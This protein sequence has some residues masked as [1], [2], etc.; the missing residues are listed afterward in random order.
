VLAHGLRLTKT[1]S[2][3]SFRQRKYDSPPWPI[4][5]YC[6]FR[7]L[8]IKKP[9]DFCVVPR[10]GASVPALF[11]PRVRPLFFFRYACAVACSSLFFFLLV[12]SILRIPFHTFPFFNLCTCSW[13]PEG[14]LSRLFPLIPFPYRSG[15]SG[16]FEGASHAPRR[17]CVQMW[18]WFNLFFSQPFFSHP[19]SWA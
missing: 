1:E 7:C 17:P 18:A 16:Y 14:V 19:L 11:C 2:R 10:W 8:G 9:A 15:D 6:L 12:S 5:G 4:M 3:A 13:L